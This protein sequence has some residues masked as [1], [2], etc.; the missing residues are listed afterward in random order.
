[1]EFADEG[2]GWSKISGQV[3]AVQHNLGLPDRYWAYTGNSTAAGLARSLGL[4]WWPGKPPREGARYVTSADLLAQRDLSVL[5][6]TATGRDVPLDAKLDSPVWRYVPARRAH[7][8]ALVER[9]IRGFGGPMSA[10][11]LADVMTD[12]LLALP[13]VR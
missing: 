6:V 12:T 4:D 11:K 10:L 5:F 2:L 13:S 1:M 3:I 8:I 9:N 7:R